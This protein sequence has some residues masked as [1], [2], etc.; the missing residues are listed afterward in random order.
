[1]GRRAVLIERSLELGRRPSH[2]K[3]FAFT[4]LC[5]AIILVLFIT[6]CYKY[7]YGQRL[8]SSESV[9]GPRMLADSRNNP[10]RCALVGSTNSWVHSR[11]RDCMVVE[12]IPKTRIEMCVI[13]ERSSI[14][15]LSQKE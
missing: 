1:M 5:L 7:S 12:L 3:H 11:L 13:S 2:F 14:R 9:L 15:T 10:T 4:L 8:F 6:P